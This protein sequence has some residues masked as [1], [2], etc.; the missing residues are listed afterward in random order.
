[1]L[2]VSLLSQPARLTLILSILF[3]VTIYQLYYYQMTKE[4]ARK[5]NS[6]VVRF[7]WAHFRQTKALRMVA[8]KKICCHEGGLGLREFYTLN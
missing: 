8:W 6:L 4:E 7:Y 2:K 1:M 3:E 5:C